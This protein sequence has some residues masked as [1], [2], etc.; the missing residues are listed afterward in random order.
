MDNRLIYGFL[1]MLF[2]AGCSSM[3]TLNL[4]I[5]RPGEY[6]FPASVTRVGIVNN[7]PEQPADE[8]SVYTDVNS[9]SHVMEIKHDSLGPLVLNGL[10]SGLDAEGY[11]EKTEI[12]PAIGAVSSPLNRFD[13]Q[14]LTTGHDVQGIISLDGFRYNANLQ[15]ILIGN[16]Y[17]ATSFHVVT[18]S[19]V[20]IYTP[21]KSTPST[22]LFTDTIYWNEYAMTPEQAHQQLPLLADA[23]KEAADNAGNRLVN[24]L[25]PY[26]EDVSR[27]YFVSPNPAMR[28]AAMYVKKNQWDDAS[29]LW[30]YIVEKSNKNN[31]RA[32]AAANL[33]LYYELQDRYSEAEEWAVKA[34]DYFVRSS[35]YAYYDTFI[36]DYIEQLRQRISD[37]IR[38]QQQLQ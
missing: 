33:A 28:D 35:R 36:N 8:N 26:K 37:D 6:S 20:R 24:R 29:Y 22:F 4:T 23:L 21:D 32:M 7:Q 18:Q 15:D 5:L 3:N 34:K 16:A 38:L 13:V 11:F 2:L 17:C 19:T 27:F 1:G 14:R 12:V 31:E 30:E 25:I 9:V 10:K